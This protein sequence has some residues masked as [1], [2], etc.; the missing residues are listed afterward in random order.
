MPVVGEGSFGCVHKPSLECAE[1]GIDYTNNVSKIMKSNDAN[2]ELKE[3]KLLKKIDKNHEHFLGMPVKCNIKISPENI[4]EIK[5]CRSADK[6]DPLKNKLIKLLILQDGG[7]NA[8]DY[9]YKMR[10]DSQLKIKVEKFYMHLYNILKSSE[11]FTSKDVA[12]R[13]I[14]LQNI[15]YN[16]DTQN[17]KLIDFGLLTDFNSAKKE[18]IK[19]DYWLNYF[20]WSIPPFAIFANESKFN[21][22]K[23]YLGNPKD[24]TYKLNLSA[25]TKKTIHELTTSTSMNNSFYG[26]F[27]RRGNFELMD[28]K[29]MFHNSFKAMIADIHKYTHAEY[30]K[31]LFK[32][33][34]VYNLGHTL[35]H[36]LTIIEPSFHTGKTYS[37]P[38]PF[39][40]DLVNL[41]FEMLSFNV[42]THITI[43]DVVKQYKKILSEH[44]NIKGYSYEFKNDTI[45]PITTAAPSPAVAPIDTS[46][47][48]PFTF[49]KKPC[50]DIK[51]LNPKTNRCV[52]RCKPGEIRDARFKCK[53]NKTQKLKSPKI[54]DD[55]KRIKQ[56]P[57]GKELNPITGRCVKKCKPGQSRDYTFKCKKNK[58]HK[59]KSSEK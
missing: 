51:E 34:D 24:P 2:D 9:L 11:F 32:T 47:V 41:S 20:F 57:D 6:Y 39:I 12:H 30:F 33:I 21:S 35:L 44:I 54:P 50:P 13:D 53:K 48:T 5:K 29:K 38:L 3:F 59:L 8:E 45:V 56:C 58:T 22:V 10:K 52:N 16:E 1:S 27:V 25:F 4:E 7:I 46:I 31:L 28:L 15:V 17:M 18:A 37:L 26:T 40:K 14:K 42:F 19:G 36:S 23:K 43:T 49:A 55:K